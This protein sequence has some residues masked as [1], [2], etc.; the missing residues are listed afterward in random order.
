MGGTGVT[1]WPTKIE[2][3]A[4]VFVVICDQTLAPLGYVQARRNGK[5][6]GESVGAGGTVQ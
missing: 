5:A 3:I 2:E 6:K 4:E 1:D